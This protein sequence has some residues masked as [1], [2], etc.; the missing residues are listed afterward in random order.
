MYLLFFFLIIH[1]NSIYLL[2]IQGY[3]YLLSLTKITLSYVIFSLY[4]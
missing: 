1:N 3:I 2:Y 4:S